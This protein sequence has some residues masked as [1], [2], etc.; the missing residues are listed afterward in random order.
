MKKS[1]ISFIII[2]KNVGATI[3]KCIQSIIHTTTVNYISDYEIIYVDSR[4]T[5]DSIEQVRKFKNCA[6]FIINGDTNAAIA[7]NIGAIEAKKEVLFFIDGDM[8]IIPETLQLLYSPEKGLIHDFV[9]GDFEDHFYNNSGNFEGFE[10]RHNLD[11]DVFQNTTGGLF[12]ITKRLW[13]QI[14]G[15]RNK[16]RIGEDFDLGLRLSEKGYKL[17]RIKEVLAKHHTVSYHRNDRL[18][19]DVMKGDF[20]YYKALLYRT[21]IY[22]KLIYKYLAREVTMFF[23]I[24]TLFLSIYLKNPVFLGV[25]LLLVLV[26]LLYKRKKIK[27]NFWS[28]YVRYIIYDVGSFLG[29]FLFWPKSNFKLEYVELKK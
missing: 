15:M 2:G 3:T 14:G 21:H 12:L 22:N 18:W 27:G 6:I 26:K 25:Y 10:K 17:L 13:L 16:F 11:K 24:I 1:N 23:F 8:E 7:R 9:S 4:S 29:F 19:A 5:D 28:L 20:L